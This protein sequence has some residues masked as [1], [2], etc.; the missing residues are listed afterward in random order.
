MLSL[1]YTLSEHLLQTIRRIDALRSDILLTPLSPKRELQYRWETNVARLHAIAVALDVPVTK[2]NVIALLTQ[3]T[4]RRFTT[5]EN[6]LAQ[7]GKTIQWLFLDWI[8]NPAQ[9]GAKTI[10]ELV[11]RCLPTLTKH[12]QH[13][14][15]YALAKTAT[16]LSTGKD[17]AA[18]QAA[19]AY[20]QIH[21]L[22]L[23]PAEK[24]PL[25]IVSAY[26]YLF[27]YGLD[28][29]GLVSY[30]HALFA[31]KK[32]YEREL[33]EAV[34]TGN[35]THWSEFFAKAIETELSQT[36][37][38]ITHGYTEGIMSAS[39][40][41]LSDRQKTILGLLDDPKASITNQKV[42][43]RF[44]VSQI[45]ASRDLARL[46]VLGLVYPRGKGRSVSYTRI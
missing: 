32:E 23:S 46:T 33:G 7:T 26:L 42:Q 31:D 11:T 40:W 17:Y 18:V 37:E 22:A 16:Y 27:K 20:E 41:Q 12:K 39:F 5:E 2:T 38:R 35:L 9:I 29:R 10:G 21:A 4:N 28:L 15:Q 19:V 34:A 44:L 1:Y 45:T 6:L 8:A 3:P 13:S 30:E 25:A 43:R 36:R 14:V 24:L